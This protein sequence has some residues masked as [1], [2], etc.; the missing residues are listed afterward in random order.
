ML[1]KDLRKIYLTH[2]RSLSA[3][4]RLEKSQ[5]ISELFFGN[6]ALEKTK[7][8]HLFLPIEKNNEIETE[9]IYRRIWQTFPGLKTAVPRINVETNELENVSFTPETALAANAWQIF[10]PVG[11]DLIEPQLLDLVIVPMLCFDERGFRVG[12]GKGYYDR[13]LA[14]CRADCLKVG[15]NYFLPIR[16]ISDTNEFDVQLDCCITP[17]RVWRFQND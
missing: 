14:R 4:E 17:E 16:E 11:S 2:Q 3:V 7:F 9:F 8:L 12:Y 6:F 15:I 5:S 10:E 13:F 1:K